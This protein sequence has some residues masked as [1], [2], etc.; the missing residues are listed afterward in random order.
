LY[1]I[2][3]AVF[4][5][6]NSVYLVPYFYRKGKVALYFSLF[7]IGIA[8]SLISFVG[9]D[10]LFTEQPFPFWFFIPLHFLSRLPY[11]LIFTLVAHLFKVRSD[12]YT[13]AAEQLTLEKA[14][15]EAELEAL[16]AQIN[17]HFLFNTLNNIQSLAFIDPRRASDSIVDLSK[18]FRYVSYDGKRKKVHVSE[19]I[20]HIE[21]YLKLAVMKK[22]WQNKVTF[23]H[24]F[25]NDLEIEPLLL[26]NFIENA[27]KHGS[28]DD[29]DDFI[30]IELSSINNTID[31][32]CKNT[33]AEKEAE[34]GSIGLQN[35]LQRLALIYPNHH[36]L[37]KMIENNTYEIHL[38]LQL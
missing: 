17:P 30:Q 25:E 28:L 4:P 38:T 15:V 1:I 9:L 32:R 13:K 3:L 14:K 19:E 33:I 37:D 7:F 8:T 29:I 18:I 31:F 26:I 36:V 12:F 35:V 27:F 6:L 16:K 24:S 2:L 5:Y 10:C 20:T 21:N 23:T 22:A 34:S 11:V